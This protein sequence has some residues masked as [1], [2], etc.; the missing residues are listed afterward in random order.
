MSFRSWLSRLFGW[1]KKC[2]TYQDPWRRKKL[3]LMIENLEQRTVPSASIQPGGTI[4][5]PFTG[6]GTEGQQVAN[7]TT[8]FRFTDP[9]PYDNAGNPAA[10]F[11][12]T[13]T[14]GDGS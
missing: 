6:T 4:F 9:G 13:I 11:K 2:F 5:P 12:A 1:K 10:D 14:W 3:H 7:G 8:L